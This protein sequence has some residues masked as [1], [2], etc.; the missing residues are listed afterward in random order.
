MVLVK[1]K[2]LLVSVLNKLYYSVENINLFNLPLKIG[3]LTLKKF[4][5]N[6]SLQR[7]TTFWK[8]IYFILWSTLNH[9]IVHYIFINS[10]W[11]KIIVNLT[12]MKGA[13]DCT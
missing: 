13:I 9:C 1:W 8:S 6:L 5:G 2:L 11:S 4:Y 12:G 7:H 10:T 3:K